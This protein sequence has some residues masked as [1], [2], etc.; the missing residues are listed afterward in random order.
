MVSLSPSEATGLFG[1]AVRG[2]AASANLSALVERAS[3][4]GAGAPA[5]VSQF[6][7]RLICRR[8]AVAKAAP[9]KIAPDGSPTVGASDVMRLFPL[10]EAL[11]S[12]VDRTR[13]CTTFEHAPAEESPRTGKIPRVPCCPARTGWPRP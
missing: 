1:N 3:A 6:R 2:A 4:I 13:P 10:A 9:G 5:V 8:L 7:R 12:L 11:A